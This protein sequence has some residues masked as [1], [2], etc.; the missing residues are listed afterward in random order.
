MLSALPGRVLF[1]LLVLVGNLSAELKSRTLG[2]VPYYDLASV[3]RNLGMRAT[4]TKVSQVIELRSQWTTLR[5]LVNSRYF[6]LNRRKVYL[7]KPVIL[8][9]GRPFLSQKDYLLTVRP[10]LCPQTLSPKRV[11]HRIVLDPGHG[12][13]DPGAQNNGVR[14]REKDLALE[15]ALRL[16]RQLLSDGYEVFLT[17]ET[18]VYIPLDQRAEFANRMRA[19]LFVS[20]HFNSVGKSTVKGVE[21]FLLPHPFTASSSR[22]RLEAIDKKSY[23]GNQNDGWNSLAGFYLHKTL[24]EQ[25]GDVD[26]GLKR[27]RLKILKNLKC[28]GMLVELAFLSHPETARMLQSSTYRNKLAVILANGIRVYGKAQLRLIRRS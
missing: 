2:G 20:I 9:Q 16:K 13:K 23:P 18:D 14:L 28:P 3:G 27:S 25:L 5:F 17:R 19:D 21:T 8:F 22:T 12:G 7:G 15:V 4:W 10:I 24:V 11:A 26:R 6:E 1:F